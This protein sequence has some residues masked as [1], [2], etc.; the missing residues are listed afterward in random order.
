MVSPNQW[1]YSL[2]LTE[3]GT[4][5]TH[6]R[7]HTDKYF[8]YKKVGNFNAGYSYDIRSSTETYIV[9]DESKPSNEWLARHGLTQFVWHSDNYTGSAT[10]GDSVGV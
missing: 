8:D 9:K 10:A 7:L 6:I 1:Y 4:P 3:K 2:E 5:H